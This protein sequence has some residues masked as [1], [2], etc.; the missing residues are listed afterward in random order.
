MN[1]RANGTPF[2][3]KLTVTPVTDS[4][5]EVSHFVGIQRDV[6]GRK[7]RERLIGVLNR[8]LRHNLRNDMNVVGGLGET[9]ASTAEGEVS[10]YGKTVAKTA[11]DLVTLTKKNKNG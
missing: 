2:W 1:Y 7:R 6:T 11:W 3:N 8:I 5:G 9:I 4:T 10:T